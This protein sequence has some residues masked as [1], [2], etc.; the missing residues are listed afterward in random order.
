MRKRIQSIEWRRPNADSFSDLTGAVEHS[1]CDVEVKPPEHSSKI[2]KVTVQFTLKKDRSEL[3]DEIFDSA[4]NDEHVD[5]SLSLQGI[6]QR[7]EPIVARINPK[8]RPWFGDRR[9]TLIVKEGHEKFAPH[10]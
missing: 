8:S 7:L 10:F 5:L 3:E 4:S 1:V 6:D 9:F 2:G